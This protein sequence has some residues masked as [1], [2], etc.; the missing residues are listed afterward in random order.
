MNT[1]IKIGQRYHFI[2]PDGSGVNGN[3][4]VIRFTAK[5]IVVLFDGSTREQAVA[6]SMFKSCTLI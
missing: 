2:H 5:R 6:A 1:E 3:L 4:T